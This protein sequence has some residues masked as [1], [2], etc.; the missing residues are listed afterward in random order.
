MY[1][2]SCSSPSLAALCKFLARRS[3][4]ATFKFG[5]ETIKTEFDSIDLVDVDQEWREGPSKDK[6]FDWVQNRDFA[7]VAIRHSRKQSMSRTNESDAI[8]SLSRIDLP[9]PQGVFTMTSLS[10]VGR[11]LFCLFRCCVIFLVSDHHRESQCV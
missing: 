3:K 10:A 9:L 1:Y 6:K 5:K 8:D 2:S 4:D 7:P 11:I